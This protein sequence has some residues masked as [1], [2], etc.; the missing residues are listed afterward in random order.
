MMETNHPAGIT[1][2]IPAYN[3]AGAIASTI[4]SLQQTLPRLGRP[5]EVIV[6]DDGSTDPTADLAAVLG[7][8]VLRHPVNSGY[9]RSLLTGIQASS[10]SVI[11]IIDADGTYPVDHLPDLLSTFDGGFDMLVG[12]RQGANYDSSL[13]KKILRA[14]FRWLAEFTCGRSI[15]DINSGFRIFRKEPVLAGQR[16]LSSGFSFTTTLTLL[17]MLNHL[18]VGFK[19]IP[20]HERIGKSKVHLLRDGLRSLQIILTA[21][22]QYNPLKLYLLLALMDAIVT[23]LLFLLGASFNR[24]GLRYCIV[25]IGSWQALCIIAGTAILSL[26]ALKPMNEW[27]APL[28]PKS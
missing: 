7:V 2:V 5:A 12:S 21:I 4:Q 22:A 14:I 13:Q 3:E 25:A 17:F 11:G 15:P 24:L 8:R 26:V 6:V 9:G 10:Y 1:I 23:I 18:F 19:A 27:H 28:P 16:A 20:Y